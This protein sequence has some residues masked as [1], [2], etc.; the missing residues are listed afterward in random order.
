[1]F[2]HQKEIYRTQQLRNMLRWVAKCLGYVASVMLH[3]HLG[4]TLG[5]STGIRS[6]R[7][8][9]SFKPTSHKELSH[10]MECFNLGKGN[11]GK[12]ESCVQ[13]HEK[14]SYRKTINVASGKRT[15]INGWNY[16]GA[17]FNSAWIIHGCLKMI[18]IT[19][20]I[21]V[22]SGSSTFPEMGSW[23]QGV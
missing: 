12:N 10:E 21:Q 7:A 8:E 19:G 4:T 11:L 5:E 14:L 6:Q 17:D 20:S 13:I 2:D 15:K 1:M 23:N 22:E 9:E 18:A 16:T 3:S